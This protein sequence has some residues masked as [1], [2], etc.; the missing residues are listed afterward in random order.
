MDITEEYS[1][2][3]RHKK[4][5]VP[6]GLETCGISNI[7]PPAQAKGSRKILRTNVRGLFLLKWSMSADHRLQLNKAV[8]KGSVEPIVVLASEKCRS[9]IK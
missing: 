1:A 5:T 8:A 2:I 4:S 3:A 7:N 9:N 6:K